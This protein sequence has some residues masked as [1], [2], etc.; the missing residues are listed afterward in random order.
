MPL[1]M[2]IFIN[3]LSMMYGHTDGIFRHTEDN[4]F[5]TDKYL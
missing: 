1:I 4:L 2:A 3:Y 5:Q